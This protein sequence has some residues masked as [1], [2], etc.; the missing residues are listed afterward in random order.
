MHATT[1]I[2]IERLR[3]HSLCPQHEQNSYWDLFVSNRI[4]DWI[5]EGRPNLAEV[6]HAGFGYL[7]KESWQKCVPTQKCNQLQ[8][9][10]IVPIA[11]MNSITAMLTE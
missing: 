1:I 7:A 10:I 2:M 5:N 3:K 9:R 11:S 8:E 6:I 4:F